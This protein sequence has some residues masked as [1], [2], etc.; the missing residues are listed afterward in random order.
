M[1]TDDTNAQ[2]IRQHQ[3]QI[4]SVMLICLLFP[5]VTALKFHVIRKN[6][7][8]ISIIMLYIRCL[9]VIKMFQPE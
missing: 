7:Y 8:S 3:H 2:N 9:M 1:H 4:I 6:T 5:F